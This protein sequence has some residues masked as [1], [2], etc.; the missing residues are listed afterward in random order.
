MFLGNWNIPKHRV[1]V[2]YL[3]KKTDSYRTLSNPLRQEMP[4]E[5]KIIAL[6]TPKDDSIL[7]GGYIVDKT[8]SF[9]TAIKGTDVEN[10]YVGFNEFLKPKKQ[11]TIVYYFSPNRNTLACFYLKNFAPPESIMPLVIDEFFDLI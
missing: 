7:M 1:I 11:S 4:D 2:Y 5:F 9:F 8:N 10:L 6:P 3:D